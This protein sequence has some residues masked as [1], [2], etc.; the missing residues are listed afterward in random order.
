MTRD[1][2]DRQFKK[3]VIS[4]WHQYIRQYIVYIYVLYAQQIYEYYESIYLYLQ[5][6]HTRY[7]LLTQF[8]TFSPVL[9]VSSAL[10]VQVQA[11]RFGELTI[12]NTTTLTTT[13][14]LTLALTLYCPVVPRHIIRETAVT[15]CIQLN[16]VAGVMVVAIVVVVVIC[17]RPLQLGRMLPITD[18]TRQSRRRTLI[19]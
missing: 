17:C 3:H 5:C 7:A 8:I 19:G 16:S 1:Y 9:V 18:N 4:T 14:Q 13:S 11:I 15:F 2:S 12:Y 6:A 10:S